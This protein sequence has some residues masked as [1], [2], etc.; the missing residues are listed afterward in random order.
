[1]V[2]YTTIPQ[3]LIM[4]AIGKVLQL[5]AHFIAEVAA[6]QDAEA[7][8]TQLMSAL[9]DI[10]KT[11]DSMQEHEDELSGIDRIQSS[12]DGIEVWQQRCPD[13]VQ[14]NDQANMTT[15]INEFDTNAL[16]YVKNILN[17]MAGQGTGLGVPLLLKPWHQ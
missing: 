7:R 5:G 9:N 2:E 13:A 14:N 17:V 16:T 15:L 1:M 3:N 4:N 11:L 10:K 12:L 8:Q 6:E